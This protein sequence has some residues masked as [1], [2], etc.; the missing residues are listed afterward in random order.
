MKKTI[1]TL[2]LLCTMV[3]GAQAQ[4]LY[5]ISGNGLAK[6]S[7]IIGTYHLANV[8]FVHSIP[9]LKK[10]LKKTTQVYG[11]LNMD[12][13][14]TPEN[15]RKM[16]QATLLPQGQKL[17]ALLTD[18]QLKRLNAYLLTAI[19]TNMSNPA[20][21]RQI[22]A[23][24][25]A[26]L[27]TQLV[28]LLYTNKFKGDFDPQHPFDTYFQ[29]QARAN[30]KYVGGLET[31]DF[32]MNLLY[33]SSPLERQIEM[34]MCLID[35]VEFS[36]RVAE[37]ITKAFYAQDLVELEKAV[38]EKLHNSCDSSPEEE[39][40]MIYNRNADWIKKMPALMAQKP[41]F[42]AVGVAHLPGDRGVLQ[43]LRNAGYT[44]KGVK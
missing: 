38:N 43:L 35:N 31:L 6:P 25:P 21:G 18:D 29:T 5:K 32:Q 16:Q 39:D 10:A 41:T 9:G 22:D 15:M 23:M 12:D 34:L 42:F 8:N 33:K 4:L 11:E 20:V 19:G 7:Y 27:S 28:M 24:L 13:M 14:K 36:E 40:R 30:H 37:R 17:S 2:L 3:W 44:V 26:A 1:T